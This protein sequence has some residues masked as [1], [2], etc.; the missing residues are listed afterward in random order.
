MQHLTEK[1]NKKKTILMSGDATFFLNFK[2]KCS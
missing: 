2:L 1:T